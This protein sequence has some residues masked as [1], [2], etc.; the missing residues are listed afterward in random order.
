[1]LA[2]TASREGEVTVNHILGN[3]DTMRYNAVPSV[4]YTNPEISCVGIS[5][6]EAKKSGIGY[7][8]RSLQ[9][10]FA[11]RFVAENEGK[12]GICK[13]IVGEKYEE[14]LGVH[15]IGNPSS[16]MIYGAAMAIENQMRLKDLEQLIFPHPTVSEIFRET[17]F[18]FHE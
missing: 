13:I 9:M 18:S 8:V 14:V 4:V 3:K 12:T 2:H 5:E 15:M 10:V 11:G 1:M 7:K 16:E 17:I 6:Q